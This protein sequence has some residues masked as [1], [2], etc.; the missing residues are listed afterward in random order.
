[1]I[2][3][4][5]LRKEKLFQKYDRQQV[6]KR[7][8]RKIRFFIGISV[9]WKNPLKSKNEPTICSKCS[10]YGHGGKKCYRSEVCPACAG[11]H[12]YSVCTLSK[13]S[14]NEPVVFKCYNCAKKNPDKSQ[15]QNKQLFSGVTRNNN[16]AKHFDN[17]NDISSDSLLDIFFEAVDALQKCQNKYDK[18]RVLG[19]MLQHVI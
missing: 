3:I 10:S 8:V 11:N 17:D 15:S 13:S 16:N 14:E 1:M 6:S 5:L 7:D 2:W 4:V 9:H 12:D 18:L 19:M